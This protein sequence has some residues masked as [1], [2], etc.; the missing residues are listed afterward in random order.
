MNKLLSLVACLFFASCAVAEN[1]YIRVVGS[2]PTLEQA[3]ELAFREA[4]QIR[5]GTIVLSE[6]ESSFENTL[7]DNVSVYSAGYVDDYRVVS[8]AT[9]NSLVEVTVD[10]LVADSKLM[11]QK[12]SQGKDKKT[13]DGEKVVTTLNSYLYQKQ[14]GDQ[15]LQTVMDSYPKNAF[16]INQQPYVLSLDVYRNTILKIPYTM[17]WNNDF[18]VAM[19][20]AMGLLEDNTYKT[21]A[22]APANI[23]ITDKYNTPNDKNW[24]KFNDMP[25]LQNVKTEISGKK[26]VRIALDF[27]NVNG[28]SLYRQCYA[29]DTIANRKPVFY[30]MNDRRGIFIFGNGVESG[31]L[32][33]QIPP[34]YNT[35]IQQTSKIELSVVSAGTCS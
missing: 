7:K 27:I 3:K 23:V 32:Q 4:I 13:F 24:F 35:V 28:K 30:N 8:V 17:Q 12:L 15:L 22:M 31:V 20:E 6:R 11:N 1:N 5:V 33:L 21:G 18:I 16:V 2:A 26:E 34:A 29:P 9:K 10:V 19:R 14:K 25:T